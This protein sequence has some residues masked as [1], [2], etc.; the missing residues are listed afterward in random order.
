MRIEKI[1]V[2]HTTMTYL[3]HILF[4]HFIHWDEVGCGVGVWVL[5]YHCS[6]ENYEVHI[7][8]RSLFNI[9]HFKIVS[10]CLVKYLCLLFVKYDLYQIYLMI[11]LNMLLQIVFE[12]SLHMLFANRTS[13]RVWGWQCQCLHTVVN[14]YLSK[15]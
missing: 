10:I 9:F 14:N 12:N 2:I 15:N 8:Q 5:E 3:P 1:N 11:I 4:P 6:I 7:F 13:F